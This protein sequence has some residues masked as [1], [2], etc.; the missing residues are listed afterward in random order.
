VKTLCE[1]PWDFSKVEGVTA[2]DPSR[3]LTA[4]EQALGY[5]PLSKVPRPREALEQAPNDVLAMVEPFGFKRIPGE[6]AHSIASENDVLGVVLSVSKTSS[7]F[8][9]SMNSLSDCRRDYTAALTQLAKDTAVVVYF[10]STTK[11]SFQR[12]MERTGQEL[13]ITAKMAD[14][15]QVQTLI[16]DIATNATDHVDFLR[17]V[18]K[19]FEFENQIPPGVD[20]AACNEFL[21]CINVAQK[22]LGRS[23]QRIF[24]DVLGYSRDYANKLAFY[25]R[26]SDV[27]DGLQAL[28]EPRD[29]HTLRNAI[30]DARTAKL[31]QRMAKRRGRKDRQVPKASE[32][33][34][35]P[36]SGAEKHGLTVAAAHKSL[37]VCLENFRGEIA[38]ALDPLVPYQTCPVL[39]RERDEL[40]A[41]VQALTEEVTALKEESGSQ[42]QEVEDMGDQ[43]AEAEVNKFKL[44]SHYAEFLDF[45]TEKTKDGDFLAVAKNIEEI[46]ERVA[47]EQE[48]ILQHLDNPEDDETE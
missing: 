29:V 44:A 11:E 15:D 28:L 1:I 38:R 37:D 21:H 10:L 48:F 18:R 24:R 47:G 40:K 7:D 6:R 23:A 20:I 39:T 8:R 34:K 33:E 13:G 19:D 45:L 35:P 41:Q 42:D 22:E 27:A 12:Q 46:R 17:R 16:T 30:D 9:A 31:A 36:L 26:Q 43:L 4:L 14:L 5:P 32:V 3:S 2:K 25:L